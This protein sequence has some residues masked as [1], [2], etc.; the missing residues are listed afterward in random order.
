[1]AL[2]GSGL[3]QR[4][5]AAQ[6]AAPQAAAPAAVPHAVRPRPC[7]RKRAAEQKPAGAQPRAGKVRGRPDT[8]QVSA[9][10]GVAVSAP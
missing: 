8:P 1:M 2:A 4:A 7:T 3:P 9:A 5:P 6:E 10:F